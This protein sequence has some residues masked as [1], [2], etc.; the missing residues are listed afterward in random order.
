[1]NAQEVRRELQG[2]CRSRGGGGGG[3]ARWRQLWHHPFPF[4]AE[5]RGGRPV[6][7]RLGFTGGSQLREKR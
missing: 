6:P 7:V 2:E 3:R 4:P 5:S 1:M